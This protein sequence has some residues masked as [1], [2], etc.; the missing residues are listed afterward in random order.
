MEKKG[1][2]TVGSDGFVDLNE[3]SVG[4][5]KVK[6]VTIDNS[7]GGFLRVYFKIKRLGA[8]NKPLALVKDGRV[9]GLRGPFNTV[10]G[11][12]NEGIVVPND[13]KLCGDIAADALEIAKRSIVPNGKYDLYVVYPLN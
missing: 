6:W 4:D 10:L 7:K 12:D 13:A 11:C 3:G 5:V 9:A 1:T 8:E 2:I